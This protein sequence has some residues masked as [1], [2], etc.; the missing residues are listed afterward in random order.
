MIKRLSVITLITRNKNRLV[1]EIVQSRDLMILWQ[2]LLTRFDEKEKKK[3]K[4][5]Y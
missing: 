3:V 5:S 1:K 2:S 4:N